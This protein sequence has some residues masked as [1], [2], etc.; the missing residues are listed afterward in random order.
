MVIKGGIQ[1]LGYLLHN[2]LY[3]ELIGQGVWGKATLDNN[4]KY[5][6]L[7]YQPMGKR[8]ESVHGQGHIETLFCAKLWHPLLY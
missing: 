1:T 2:A 7:K 6:S 3:S 4:E 5:N 8:A